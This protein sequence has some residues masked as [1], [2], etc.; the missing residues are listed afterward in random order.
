MSRLTKVS[1]SLPESFWDC[2]KLGVKGDA[3][4]TP[5]ELF[6]FGSR[7][8]TKHWRL[9]EQNGSAN[10]SNGRYTDTF[11]KWEYNMYSI[12]CIYLIF[13]LLI[14]HSNIDQFFTA[15]QKIF[16]SC[17]P[18]RRTTPAFEALVWFHLKLC[19]PKMMESMEE[20]IGWCG[21]PNMR[22]QRVV[23]LHTPWK[24]NI[25]LEKLPS[26]KE[27][28]CFFPSFLRGYAKLRGCTWRGS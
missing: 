11:V 12:I 20:G 17:S 9:T 13:Y 23:Q 1:A 8:E 3:L 28:S 26:Q 25:V 27:S 7:D 5:P 22:K 2:A 18:V 19:V 21:K 14:P 6:V 10:W 4:V 16:K 24:L 15:K